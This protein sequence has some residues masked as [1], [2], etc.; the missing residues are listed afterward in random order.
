VI[1]AG[2]DGVEIHGANHYLIHQFVSPYYNRRNDEWGE[3]RLKFAS[4]VVDEVT[5]TVKKYG[6]KDFIVGYR[7][8]PEEAESPGISME[9]TETL[10]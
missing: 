1:E 2:F 9:I 7:F 6:N 4:L 5:E 8:S 3:D 10:I